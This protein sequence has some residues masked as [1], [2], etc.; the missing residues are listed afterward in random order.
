MNSDQN[1]H[2]AQQFLN[3]PTTYSSGRVQHPFRMPIE[4]GEPTLNAIGHNAIYHY[5]RLSIH[6]S[7]GAVPQEVTAA[8]GSCPILSLTLGP[9][10]LN[11]LGLVVD[12][13]NAI[14]V[15]IVAQS[16]PGNLLCTV[17]NLLNNGGP[18]TQ[19]TGLLNQILGILGV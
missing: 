4:G 12:I 7:T 5:T 9:L 3:I 18:L 16:G 6:N 19:I 2:C 13:P 1:S 15:N 14:V 17:A 11:V 8:T 10:N